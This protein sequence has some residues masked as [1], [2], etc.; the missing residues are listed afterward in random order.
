[1][2]RRSNLDRGLTA[3]EVAAIGEAA[4]LEHKTASYEVRNH[5]LRRALAEIGYTPLDYIRARYW[6]RHGKPAGYGWD[7][8]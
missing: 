3:H 8:S 7:A 2:K 6:L 5:A 4:Q 1:M